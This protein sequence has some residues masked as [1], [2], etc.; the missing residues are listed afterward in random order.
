[1]RPANQTTDG[2]AHRTEAD[3]I[4]CT[5]PNAISLS[6]LILGL[7]FPWLPAV[8][9][10]PAVVAGAVSDALDG[11]SGRVFRSCSRTGKVLD[12]VADKVFVAGVVVAFLAGGVLTPT[13]V[14]LIGLRDV[15][16]VTGT[17]IALTWWRREALRGMAPTL[18]GK[19]TTA[20]QFA[21]FGVLLLAP[22]FRELALAVT[23]GLSVLAAGH[24]LWLFSRRGDEASDGPQR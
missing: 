24:Y 13:E 9:Q 23:A 20:A 19:A 8:W 7:C 4:V 15:T 16:V 14:V 17:A 6:R 3:V 10:L 2:H 12:P 18:L 1:M 11:A 22:R 5:I 21:F